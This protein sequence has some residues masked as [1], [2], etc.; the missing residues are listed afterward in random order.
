MDVYRPFRSNRPLPFSCGWY[1][2]PAVLGFRGYRTAACDPATVDL[3]GSTSGVVDSHNLGGWSGRSGFAPAAFAQSLHLQFCEIFQ[4]LMN[5]NLFHRQLL[6]VSGSSRA[7]RREAAE[8]RRRVWRLR[9]VE[10]AREGS[11]QGKPIPACVR[12]VAADADRLMR[13]TPQFKSEILRAVDEFSA[14]L[15]LAIDRAKESVDLSP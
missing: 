8:E 11:K 4:E 14:L 3:L 2:A 1:E 10:I 13:E 6:A 5:A 9:W 15:Y 12:M 7:A